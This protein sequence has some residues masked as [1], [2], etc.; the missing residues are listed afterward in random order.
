MR[1]RIVSLIA[2]S[3]VAAGMFAASA[4]AAKP[5]FYTAPPHLARYAIGASIK[6]AK[7]ARVDPAVAR[8]GRLLRFM[9]RSEDATGAPRAETG[10]I[11]V[12]HGKAPSGGWPVVAWDHGTTGI[13]PACAPSRVTN[14]A[15]YAPYL[16]QIASRGYVV[17]APDYEGLGLPGEVSTF[18]EL[19]AEGRSTVDAVRAARAVVPNLTRQWVVL[20]H[21]QG[22]Q[23][24]LGTAQ[25]A[26]T[27]APELPLIGTVP[28][29]PASHFADALDILGSAVPPKAATLPEAA[30]LLL[31]AQVS[32]PRFDPATIVSPE[33]AAGFKLAKT[34][35]YAQLYAYYEKHPAPVLFTRSWRDSD[36]LRLFASRNDPGTVLSPGP[37]LLVQGLADTTIPPALT[38]ALNAKLC[39][40]GQSVDFRTYPGVQHNE[41]PEASATDVL[42]WVGDRFAGRP[43]SSTCATT[44][45]AGAGT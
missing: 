37:M 17:V 10:V 34:A 35:C 4:S 23:A 30:Y 9:Y 21:S 31:S 12:P 16:A 41:A 27:R 19:T 39:G 24:A 2:V 5:G 25:V 3:A 18:A 38:E 42:A 11:I 36:A 15:D 1:S 7:A 33:V 13:G 22:G 28:M 40:L 14:L 32:D 29:A 8:A 43:A 20:G 45:P 6:T 26:G 44:A